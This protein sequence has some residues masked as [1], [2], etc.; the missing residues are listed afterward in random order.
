M[1]KLF[2]IFKVL[3]FQNRIVAELPYMRKYG[4]HKST[5]V[6]PIAYK[7][8]YFCWNLCEIKISGK[9]F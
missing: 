9:H 8:L 6:L 7:Y 4:I 2:E 5:V 1:R 3:Q